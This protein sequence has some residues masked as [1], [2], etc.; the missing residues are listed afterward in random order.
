[1]EDG[2]FELTF[3]LAGPDACRLERIAR[4]GPESRR[5]ESPEATASPLALVF[6]VQLRK[7]LVD[8]RGQRHV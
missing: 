4:P 1:M 6:V 7:T 2:R 3:P 8:L 5:H